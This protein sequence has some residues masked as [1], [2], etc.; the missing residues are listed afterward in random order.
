MTILDRSLEKFGA[1]RSILVDKHG[2]VVAGNK[3]LEL[4][5]EQGFKSVVVPSDGTKL[6]VVQRTDLDI[7]SPETRELAYLDNRSAELGLAW[8]PTRLAEDLS[9]GIELGG[10]F[11]EDERAAIMKPLVVTQEEGEFHVVPLTVRL[12]FKDDA[13]FQQWLRL[14]ADIEQRYVGKTHAEKLVKWVMD[15]VDK[16]EDVPA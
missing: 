7:T 16:L 1:G 11:K 5:V 13:E 4:A 10:M 8:D 12:S 3:T 6:V 15:Q 2:M 9:S 14:M